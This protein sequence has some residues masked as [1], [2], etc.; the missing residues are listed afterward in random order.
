MR[1]S[2]KRRQ[3]ALLYGEAIA[4]DLIEDWIRDPSYFPKGL[5]SLPGMA[6]K[7]ARSGLPLSCKHKPTEEELDLAQQRASDDLNRY[8]RFHMSMVEL[9]LKAKGI[10]PYEVQNS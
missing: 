10:N 5:K 3:Y 2:N 6:G 1:L 8:I 9:N 7:M 4:R